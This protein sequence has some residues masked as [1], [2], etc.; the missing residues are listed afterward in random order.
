MAYIGRAPSIG[1][2]TKQDL[3]GDGSTTTFTLTNT[4]G[5]ESAML[6]SVGGVIQEPKVE[7]D[8]KSKGKSI[9]LTIP[10]K[11]SLK[12]NLISDMLRSLPYTGVKHDGTLTSVEFA[13][14]KFPIS[15][16]HSFPLVPLPFVCK[17]A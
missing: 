6:V 3:T 13:R 11:Y 7:V 16:T 9:F 14:N 4:V 12:E 8:P 5:S 15:E 1:T 2:F 17:S 10:I